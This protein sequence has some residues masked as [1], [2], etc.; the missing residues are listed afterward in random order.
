MSYSVRLAHSI[1]FVVNALQ[2]LVV[3]SVTLARCRVAVQASQTSQAE[4]ASEKTRAANL[5][6]RYDEAQKAT[7]ALQSKV[8]NSFSPPSRSNDGKAAFCSP[9]M[10]PSCILQPCYGPKPSM[11]IGLLHTCIV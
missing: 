6:Q 1:T 5:Q 3:A 11:L 2:L 9:V 4:L 7:T 8:R 10:V